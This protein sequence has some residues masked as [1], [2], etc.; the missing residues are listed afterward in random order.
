MPHVEIQTPRHD[1]Q[2]CSSWGTR[3]FVDGQ[4]LS[5]VR[6]V[7][8]RI[9]VDEAVEVRATVVATKEFQLSTGAEL[10]VTV[11]AF[12]GYVLVEEVRA[13]GTKAYRVES[14]QR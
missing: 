12:P 4:E 13:D 3:V 8:V 1:G 5:D 7:S 6:D 9:A 14:E 11:L 2:A 10:H